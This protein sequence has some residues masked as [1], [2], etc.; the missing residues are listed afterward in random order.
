MKRL[1]LQCY[2]YTSITRRLRAQSIESADIR[3]VQS[4]LPARVLRARA[5]SLHTSELPATRRKLLGNLR[6]TW[7]SER[8]SDRRQH[9][10]T[11]RARVQIA[12]MAFPK[13]NCQRSIIWVPVKLRRLHEITKK[14][15]Y[16]I[17]CIVICEFCLS[18][19]SN[20]IYV[21]DWRKPTIQYLIFIIPGTR[22]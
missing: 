22:K 21:T 2:K 3:E 11:G 5:M 13:V 1:T 14:Y 16:F 8:C 15:I 7:C 19:E 9:T 17:V 18:K 6:R 4:R 10:Q 12:W 20:L